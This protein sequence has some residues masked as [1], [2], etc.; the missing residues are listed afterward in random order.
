MVEL[1]AEDGQRGEHL[2]PAGRLDADEQQVDL[3]ETNSWRWPIFA[4][5][6]MTTIGYVGALLAFQLGTAL[7]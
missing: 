5:V 2:F 6:Y 1:I 7:S 3:R 4:W